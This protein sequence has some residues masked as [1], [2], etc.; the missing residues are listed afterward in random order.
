MFHDSRCLR[1]S[2]EEKQEL[3]RGVGKERRKRERKT[4]K[5]EKRRRVE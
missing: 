2:F 1:L 3:R 4:W 5:M